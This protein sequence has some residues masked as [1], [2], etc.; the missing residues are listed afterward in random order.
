MNKV[1]DISDVILG[2]LLRFME[3]NN[4]FEVPGGCHLVNVSL[5]GS[6]MATGR[7]ETRH[8]ET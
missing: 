3:G 7:M 8:G 6:E 1:K 4:K 2:F 5:D